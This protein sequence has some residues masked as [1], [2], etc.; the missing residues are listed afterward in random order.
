MKKRFLLFLIHLWNISQNGVSLHDHYAIYNNSIYLKL[1]YTCMNSLKLRYMESRIDVMAYE[2]RR[3]LCAV[4][5]LVPCTTNFGYSFSFETIFGNIL[6]YYLNYDYYLINHSKVKVK[7]IAISWRN[8]RQRRQ[9]CCTILCC[10]LLLV[11]ATLKL[12]T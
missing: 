9:F 5:A 12:R 2:K 11:A 8:W 4:T 3:S 7:N 6:N 10:C 1:E